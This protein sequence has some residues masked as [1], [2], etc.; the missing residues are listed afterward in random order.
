MR[1]AIPLLPLYPFIAKPQ[2][3]VLWGPTTMVQNLGNES[4]EL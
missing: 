3:Y 4:N 2:F 1:T